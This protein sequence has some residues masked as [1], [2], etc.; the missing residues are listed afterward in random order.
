MGNYIHYCSPA[1]RKKIHKGTLT[2]TIFEK[3]HCLLMYLSSFMVETRKIT[4]EFVLTQ[5]STRIDQEN[6]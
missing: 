2:L 4:P 6:V 1:P 3:M 5:G